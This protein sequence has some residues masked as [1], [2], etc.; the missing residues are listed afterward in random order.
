MVACFRRIQGYA[1]TA[2]FDEYLQFAGSSANS[3][4]DMQFI[5]LFEHAQVTSQWK[6]RAPYEW[7]ERERGGAS[8]CKY[9][10]KDV[11]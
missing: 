8:S 5:E 11:F 10:T 1:L 9:T 6:E 4:L 7:W 2:A 3:D